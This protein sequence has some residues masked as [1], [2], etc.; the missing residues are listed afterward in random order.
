MEKPLKRGENGQFVPGTGGGGRNKKLAILTE[1]IEDWTTEH[2]DELHRQ[3]M[4]SKRD[5]DR[6]AAIELLWAYC[7]GKPQ[8]F[9]NHNVADLE[10]NDVKNVILDRLSKLGDK[11]QELSST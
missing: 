6:R 9:I 5:S 7:W 3:A 10:V 1:K 4:G 2:A 8:Q 11:T